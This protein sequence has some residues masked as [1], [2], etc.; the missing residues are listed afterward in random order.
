MD[1]S[2]SRGTGDDADHHVHGDEDYD[3]DV[4]EY[5]DSKDEND[6]NYVC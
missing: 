2:R 6:D 3:E 4:D 1:P 5:S